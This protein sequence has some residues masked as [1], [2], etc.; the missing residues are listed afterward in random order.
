VISPIFH[1]QF[2]RAAII[3]CLA[4]RF[5][6]LR[7][8]SFHKTAQP[9]QTGSGLLAW[10]QGSR[11]SPNI[12]LT[13][14]YAVACVSIDCS[15]YGITFRKGQFKSI[16]PNPDKTERGNYVSVCED[17]NVRDFG[18]AFA[19]LNL[20]ISWTAAPAAE[21]KAFDTDGSSPGASSTASSRTCAT[22]KP[23]HG[24]G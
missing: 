22:T 6:S 17:I 7:Q 2:L 13:S 3:I 18:R 15:L 10:V 23:P 11:R 9:S 14:L 21:G 19:E 8:C 4:L 16:R 5:Q 24:G 12:H 1:I 20:D